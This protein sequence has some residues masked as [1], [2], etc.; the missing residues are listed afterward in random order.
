MRTCHPTTSLS[1][2]FQRVSSAREKA[3]NLPTTV[4]QGVCKRTQD[5]ERH[6]AGIFK[7]S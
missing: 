5:S 4:G 6:S 7:R 2:S 1:S 3:R